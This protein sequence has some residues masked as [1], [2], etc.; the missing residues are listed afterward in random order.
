[1]W[2]Q[3]NSLTVYLK[4]VGGNTKVRGGEDYKVHEKTE[5][6]NKEYKDAGRSDL[7]LSMFEMFEI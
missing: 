7:L 2:K 6:Q 5:I 4:K 3:F 1:M